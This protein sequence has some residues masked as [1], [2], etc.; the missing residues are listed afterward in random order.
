MP[1]ASSRDASPNDNRL[2]G[3]EGRVKEIACS[4]N[5][6][7]SKNVFITIVARKGWHAEKGSKVWNS[8]RCMSIYEERKMNKHIRIV[9]AV[10]LSH[11]NF[12]GF[13]ELCF[14]LNLLFCHAILCWPKP[15]STCWLMGINYSFPNFT[16]LHNITGT[17]GSSTGK[18][19][20]ETYNTYV[21]YKSFCLLYYSWCFQRHPR[22]IV[23]FVI[24]RILN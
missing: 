21:P 14:S 2:L 15:Y 23:D 4:S 17:T 3:Q 24:S 20:K 13:I 18:T 6:A 7:Y 22:E 16:L 9:A 19:P 8:L 12:V 5:S 1:W 11:F 10:H